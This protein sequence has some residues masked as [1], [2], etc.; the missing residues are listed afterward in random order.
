MWCSFKLDFAVVC[1][2]SFNENLIRH[3]KVFSSETAM[4]L[5]WLETDSKGG[6]A[7]T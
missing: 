5:T 7:R 4:C 3:L 2:E 1:L 6:V